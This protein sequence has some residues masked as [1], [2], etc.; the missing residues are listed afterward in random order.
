MTLACAVLCVSAGESFLF[1]F[2]NGLLGIDF[3]NTLEMSK[4]ITNW[5]FKVNIPLS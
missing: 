3:L 2:C 4:L 1:R 5:K